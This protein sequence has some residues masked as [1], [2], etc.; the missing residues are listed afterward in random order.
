MKEEGLVL[1]L[2]CGS[3]NCVTRDERRQVAHRREESRIYAV[4]LLG[5]LVRTGERE[6]LR[7]GFSP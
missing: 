4:K 1:P 3:R 6:T 7:R 2:G 5:S